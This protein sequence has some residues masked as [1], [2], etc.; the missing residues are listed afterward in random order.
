MNENIDNNEKMPV[1]NER[2]VINLIEGIIGEKP[3]TEIKKLEDESGLLY[4]LVI[5]V[6]GDDGDPVRYDYMRAGNFSE[7]ISS[8]TALD[9]IYLDGDGNVVGGD[10]VSKYIDGAWVS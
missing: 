3:Y 9:V 6:V 8:E 5:E 1:P 10:C 2:E 7:E 4:R